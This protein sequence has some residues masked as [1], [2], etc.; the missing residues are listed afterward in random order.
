MF[1]KSSLCCRQVP[2]LVMAGLI[3]GFFP[4]AAVDTCAEETD[5]PKVVYEV[6]YGSDIDTTHY[7]YDDQGHRIRLEKMYYPE[8]DP[9]KTISYTYNEAGNLIHCEDDYGAYSD[10]DED[11]NL[12]YHQADDGD[13][14]RY[15]ELGRIVE[16]VD[17]NSGNASYY[18]YTY[19]GDT[20]IY[21]KLL[22]MSEGE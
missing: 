15:D 13:Y 17:Q 9:Y 21:S 16:E 6:T 5:E 11:G 3:A 4:A 19:E 8:T 7:V 1:S 22:P 10:F 2:A 20:D 12:L 14:E 18:T